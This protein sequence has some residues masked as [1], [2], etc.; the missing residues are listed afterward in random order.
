MPA[1]LNPKPK[2]RNRF[3]QSGFTMIE[4]MVVIVILAMAAAL[5]VPRLPST[6][7]T[8]LKNSAGNLAS[9]IRFLNDRAIVSKGIYR[10]HFNIAENSLSVVKLSDKGEEV[11]PDDQFFTRKL[12]ADGIIIED[13]TAPR[14][15]KMTEGDVPITFGPMGMP[16]PLVVHLKGEEKRFTVTAYPNGGKVVVQEGYQEVQPESPK[17]AGT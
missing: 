8:K 10:L 2:T 6:E 7:G 15:G 4:L 5:V 12:L 13:V 14:L 9:A 16:E 11:A 17:E 1:T 3:T